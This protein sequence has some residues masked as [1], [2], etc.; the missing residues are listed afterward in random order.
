MLMACSGIL[1]LIVAQSQRIFSLPSFGHISRVLNMTRIEMLVD[2]GSKLMAILLSPI[3]PSFSM[4]FSK[5]GLLRPSRMPE[6]V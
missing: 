1:V 5:Y 3:H 4:L 2:F 6:A